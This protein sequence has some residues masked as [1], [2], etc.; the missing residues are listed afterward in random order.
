VFYPDWWFERD[1]IIRK[2]SSVTAIWPGDYFQADDYAVANLGQLKHVTVQAKAELEALLGEAGPGEKISNLVQSWSLPAPLNVVRDDY[3]VLNQGQLK[4][5]AGLFYERLHD[6]GYVGAPL[7]AGQ[8]SPWDGASQPPDSFAAANLGQLKFLFSFDPKIWVTDT[9]QDGMEDHWES[10]HGLD[11]ANSADASFDTEG[12]GVS[13]LQEFK[14]RAD[15]F[16]RDTDLDG[17]P[18]AYEIAFGLNPALADGAADKD[19]DGVP[20][21]ED[22]GLG[23]AGIGRLAVSIL[24]PSQG[25]AF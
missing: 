21:D 10:A 18:D 4:F 2:P 23:D 8:I 24:N 7:E 15:P 1:V 25:A 12:D 20:N 13:N 9:D 22:A 17:S 14:F 11:P 19:G 16:S 5:I 3:G 6:F